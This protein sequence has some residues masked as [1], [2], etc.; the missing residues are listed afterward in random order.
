MPS[1]AHCASPTCRRGTSAILA[2][3]RSRVE[4]GASLAAALESFPACFNSMYTGMVRAGERSGDLQSALIRLSQ[5]LEREDALRARLLSASIYPML[6]AGAGG[7]A[8]TILLAIVLP[9]FAVLL[10]DSGA[11]LPRSTALLIAL[12][13]RLQESWPIL[14][15]AAVAFGAING[16]HQSRG[17]GC[18]A[19]AVLTLPLLRAL[20]RASLTGRFAMTGVL[21]AGGATSSAPRCVANSLG[22]VLA[23]DEV[24]VSAHARRACH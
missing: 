10:L 24:F 17:S 21:L 13:G 16:L 9:R 15:G 12:S 4:R 20:R 19:M 11:T 23:R 14:V 22:D 2:E 3:V 5:Q 8:V 6:L 7:V 18:W 1:L